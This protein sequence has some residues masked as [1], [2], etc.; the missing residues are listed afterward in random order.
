MMNEALMTYPD[1]F[2]LDVSCE[3]AYETTATDL[4]EYEEYLSTLENNG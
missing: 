1:D 2:D 4:T 3:E